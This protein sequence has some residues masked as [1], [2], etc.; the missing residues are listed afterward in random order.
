MIVAEM[1]NKINFPGIEESDVR[2]IDR[3]EDLL[4]S[5]VF[6]I[7]KNLSSASWRS[8]LPEAVL[9][10]FDLNHE[11]D[12]WN[13]YT[14]DSDALDLPREIRSTEP[15]VIIETSKYIVFIEVKH[16]SSFGKDAGN[17]IHQL[18]RQWELGSFMAE[19]QSKKFQLITLT[20]YSSAMESEIRSIFSAEQIDSAVYIRFWENL[21]Q[22]LK[23]QITDSKVELEQKFL[24]DLEQYLRIKGFD[25]E[26]AVE[27]KQLSLDY[28]FGDDD[29]AKFKEK[30]QLAIG[31][32]D[33]DAN[34]LIIP[35]LRLDPTKYAL[36]EEA[37]EVLYNSKVVSHTPLPNTIDED[38][39]IL[40]N[41]LLES[42]DYS[43]SAFW[44]KVLARAY[45]LPYL[46][47]NGRKDFSVKAKIKSRGNRE[48]SLFTARASDFSIQIQLKR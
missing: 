17:G 30:L 5:N 9:E 11:I 25:T 4:T 37:L 32:Y 31:E 21:Y 8:L 3:M 29:S 19:R 15:D 7:L 35:L 48:I 34:A 10:D 18:L 43:V 38:K 22:S 36:L 26:K 20:P 41:F 42:E 12:F 39:S 13:R 45:Y 46:R 44:Y 33:T 24:I 14:N 1:K 6:G 28:Y 27:E 23:A 47:L 2:E 40:A 16:C